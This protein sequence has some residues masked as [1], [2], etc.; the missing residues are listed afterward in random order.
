M[1][2]IKSRRWPITALYGLFFLCM[3]AALFY[4]ITLRP[5][6]PPTGDATVSLNTALSWVAMGFVAGGMLLMSLFV[7]TLF[8]SR[9][10]EK[11]TLYF[12]T[13]CAAASARVLFQE[14]GI[15]YEL[16]AEARPVLIHGIRNLSV[17]IL[18]AGLL[19]FL[20]EVFWPGERQKL[21]RAL[22]S[23]V[24]VF[25]AMSIALGLYRYSFGPKIAV[26]YAVVIELFMIW[27]MI[28]SPR[29]K[30]PWVNLL[31]FLCFL[32]YTATFALTVLNVPWL[33]NIHVLSTLS[34]VAL[35]AVMLARRYDDAVRAVERANETLETTVSQRTAELRDAN[36]HLTA[37]QTA[38]RDMIA[39]VSHDLKTPL[40]S[41]NNFLEVLGDEQAGLTG[42]EQADY[43]SAA[44]EKNLDLQRLIQRLFE[45]ARMESGLEDRPE[46]LEVPDLLAQMT[47]KY[48]EQAKA[49]GVTFAAEADSPFR[50]R[51]DRHRLWSVLDNV[52]YNALRHTPMSG[53]ITVT[54][55]LADGQAVLRIADTGEGIAAE[56]LP[57]VFERHYK[58]DAARSGKSGDSG[59]GLYIVKTAM[60][61]M[62]G[63]VSIESVPGRGTSVTLTLPGRG[64]QDISFDAPGEIV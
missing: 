10:A 38:L 47:A 4:Y 45:A 50:L 1:R 3:L 42:P 54:A 35:Q 60:E 28:T 14:G 55:E 52:V 26:A 43:L 56:H 63:T 16:L 27:L 48:R 33:P 7:F 15:A 30:K 31:Y 21:R 17:A 8:L 18:S 19:G 12:S 20:F 37:S 2:Q 5:A 36:D 41:L 25:V 34:L 6:S 40:T 58:G 64:A 24:F 13:I 61:A 22:L 51:A 49:R 32:L 59:L 29:L 53:S 57:H 62:E 23:S 39:A 46:W 9:P 11:I 44:Y